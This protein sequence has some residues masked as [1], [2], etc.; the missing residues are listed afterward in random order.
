M[1]PLVSFYGMVDRFVLRSY[2]GVIAV[3]DEVK[4]KLLKAGVRAKKIHLIRNGIDMRPFAEATPSLRIDG[5]GESAL[6]VGW[7]GRLSNEKGADIFLRAAARVLTECP[8]ARFVVVGDGPD[9]A[10]SMP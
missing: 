9:L 6:V 7:I 2:A 1:A 3:S 10:L 5:D 4:A 8:G